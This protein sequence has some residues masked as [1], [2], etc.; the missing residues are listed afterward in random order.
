M[1]DQRNDRTADL[2]PLD[3]LKQTMQ[4]GSYVAEE[5]RGAAGDVKSVLADAAQI[6]RDAALRV[7]E[8]TRAAAGSAK[9]AME[10]GAETIGQVAQKMAQE[11]RDTVL[12]WQL[13]AQD[14][15]QRRPLQVVAAAA[16]V[17]LLAG[18]WLGRARRREIDRDVGST[19]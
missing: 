9:V 16:S 13:C 8:H 15:I 7:R 18:L 12:Y 5:A 6:S 17:G 14:Y 3:D 10:D 4:A 2:A 1:N 11:Q 19:H